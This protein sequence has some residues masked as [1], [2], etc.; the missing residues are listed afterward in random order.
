M[1]PTSLCKKI[2]KDFRM[3]EEKNEKKPKCLFFLVRNNFNSSDDSSTI[4]W[5]YKSTK[6]LVKV[7]TS[8][9]SLWDIY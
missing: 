2:S 5:P 9:Y 8:F 1:L 6:L 3:S 7:Y 4:G